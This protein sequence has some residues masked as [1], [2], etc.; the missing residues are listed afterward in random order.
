MLLWAALR[1]H[2]PWGDEE[3]FLE[4]VRLFGEGIT[5]ELL[6]SY[7]EMTGPLTYLVYAAWGHLAG[8]GTAELRLLS[9]IVAAVTAL[10]WYAFL[11]DQVRSAV[12]V[13]LALA[14]VVLNPYFVGLSVFVFTDMLALLG[15]SFAA[16][17]VSRRWPVLTT[18]GIVVA[19][20]S[21]QYLVFLPVAL[22]V[23]AILSSSRRE[24]IRDLAIPAVLGMVPLGL[25][26]LLWGGLAPANA[27]RDIYA[28]EALRFYP[29]TL[30]L[31]LAAPALYLAPLVL[32]VWS[33]RTWP[34]L[35]TSVAFMLVV[36]AF[37]V[38]VSEVQRM[39]D[40]VTVGFLHRAIDFLLPG[41]L[42]A[43][44]LF[45]L[46]AAF[47]GGALARLI[48][49]RGIELR[50]MP[51]SERFIWMAIAAFLIVMPFS[52]M[53]WEKYALPLFMLQGAAFAIFLD[54]SRG[55]GTIPPS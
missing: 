33:R 19:T 6:R 24:G 11:R 25:L 41:G 51:D 50:Q 10:A 18:V 21:R 35:G 2:P 27:M 54:R 47:N 26:M 48:S 32:L 43:L 55:R 49:S 36:V 28:S 30:S 14:T 12:F 4:T 7:P 8:F 45:P 22:V 23:V 9:P 34:M 53:P 3:H 31:Y 16:L 17:G 52:Y 46:L 37:P 15:L 29:N 1:N 38:Q 42:G 13:F 39:G 20:C 5:W 44:V 40:I